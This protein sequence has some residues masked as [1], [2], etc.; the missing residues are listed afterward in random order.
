MYL[1]K[2]RGPLWMQAGGLRRQH[3]SG[4]NVNERKT[5][6]KNISVDERGSG[7]ERKHDQRQKNADLDTFSA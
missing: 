5:Y 3:K 4:K 7:K 6:R 2:E 1:H